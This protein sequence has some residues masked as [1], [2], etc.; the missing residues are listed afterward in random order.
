[1]MGLGHTVAGLLGINNFGHNLFIDIFI[2]VLLNIV[3]FLIVC[4]FGD[5]SKT[6]RT[7]KESM[8]QELKMCNTITTRNILNPKRY[9]TTDW[10]FHP[11]VLVTFTLFPSLRY[12]MN[13]ILLGVIYQRRTFKW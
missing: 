1:M 6:N 5:G 7:L 4:E 2:S 12:K 13:Q 3:D 11:L 9:F 10:P 8:E